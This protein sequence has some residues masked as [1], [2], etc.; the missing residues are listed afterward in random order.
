MFKLFLGEVV[1][2]VIYFINRI[3]IR[4][5]VSRILY[6]VFKNKKLKFKVINRDIIF[7][8]IR[9]W[10]WNSIEIIEIIRGG[11]SII[12]GDLGNKGVNRDDKV[13]E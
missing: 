6:E 10:K 7:D 2:Y 8:K 1:R 4:V 11:F 12:F 3:V 5:F 13:I 9:K